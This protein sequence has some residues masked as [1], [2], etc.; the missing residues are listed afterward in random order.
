MVS[1]GGEV[2]MEPAEAKDSASPEGNSS[3]AEEFELTGT[4]CIE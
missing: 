1:A 4:R 3:K 2:A